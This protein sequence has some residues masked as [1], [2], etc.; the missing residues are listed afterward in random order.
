MRKAIQ[1]NVSMWIEGEDE[2]AHNFVNSSIQNIK[3][4]ISAGRW[5]HPG[6]SITIKNIVEETDYDKDDAGKPK[7]I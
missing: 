5:R 1:L 6:M 4:I 2:P 7:P 3:D